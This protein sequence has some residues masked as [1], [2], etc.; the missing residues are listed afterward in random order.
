MLKT[1]NITPHSNENNP[2][3]YQSYNNAIKHAKRTKLNEENKLERIRRQ[4]LKWFDDSI[5]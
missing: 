4:F 3:T 1:H 5:I 2:K